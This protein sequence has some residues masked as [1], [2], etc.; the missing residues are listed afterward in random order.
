M[1]KKAHIFPVIPGEFYSRKM[2][3]LEEYE[4]MV[5]I[6]KLRQYRELQYNTNLFMPPNGWTDLTEI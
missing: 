4:R 1:R 2:Y 3:C 5:T 6:I